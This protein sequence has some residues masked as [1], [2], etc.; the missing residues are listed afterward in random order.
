[1]CCYLQGK[2][3]AA[4]TN[5]IFYCVCLLLPQLSWYFNV[6]YN[7]NNDNYYVIIVSLL[8]PQLS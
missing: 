2:D 6:V 7:Y 5:N 8:L 4:P 3:P 1:M